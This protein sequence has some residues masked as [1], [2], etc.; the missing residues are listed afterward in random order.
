MN[1]IDEAKN[2][3]RRHID[4]K[5]FAETNFILGSKITRKFEGIFLD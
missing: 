3:L 1:F 4:M 5:D 2:I